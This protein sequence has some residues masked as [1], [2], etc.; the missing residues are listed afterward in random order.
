MSDDRPKESKLVEF[1]EF[2]LAWLKK[3]ADDES[4]KR[5]QF[6]SVN[7]LIRE[8]VQCNIEEEQHEVGKKSAETKYVEI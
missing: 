4:S 8:Y 1:F 5:G 7:M 6:I 2:Q 3:K